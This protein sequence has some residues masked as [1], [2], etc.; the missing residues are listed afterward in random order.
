[1]KLVTLLMAAATFAGLA[2]AWSP[3][4]PPTPHPNPPRPQPDGYGRNRYRSLDARKIGIM[5]RDLDDLYADLSARDAEA[6][7]ELY[8]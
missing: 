2:A 3:P 6:E 5:A 1:M 4:R 8:Y 7:D